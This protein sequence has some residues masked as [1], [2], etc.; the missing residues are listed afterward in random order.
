MEQFIRADRRIILDGIETAIGCSHGIAY[1]IMHDHLKFWKGCARWVPRELKD[2]EKMN[3][4]GLP[5]QHLLWYAVEGEDMFNRIVTRNELWVL[6]YQPESKRAS[7]Q[8]KRPSSPSTKKFKVMPSAGKVMLTIF[9]DSEGVLLAHFQKRGE[10]V[11]SSS[12]CEVLLKPW[13]AIF[14]KHPGQLARWFLL[15]HDNA[16]PHRV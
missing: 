1:G 10:N 3:R 8:W 13:D 11:N 4:I 2:R 15:H 7:V 5:L 12:Y 16:R 14:R 9:W 6:H